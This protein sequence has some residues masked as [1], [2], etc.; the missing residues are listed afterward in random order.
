VKASEYT[1]VNDS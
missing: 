1:Q